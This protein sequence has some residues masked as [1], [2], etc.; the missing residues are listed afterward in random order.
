MVVLLDDNFATIVAAAEEGRVSSS[1]IF[2]R[3]I[4]YILAATSAKFWQ[5]CGRTFNGLFWEECRRR[6]CKQDELS[7]RRV[8]ALA[9]EPA[10][11]TR[12]KPFQSARKYFARGLGSA[13]D[14]A[15]DYFCNLWRDRDDVLAYRN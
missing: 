14:L 12:W 1:A 6:R 13:Y 3:F 11:R 9:V 4:K 7:N 2:G 15:W 5:N 8:P 10:D